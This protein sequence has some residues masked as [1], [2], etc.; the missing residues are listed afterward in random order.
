MNDNG[1]LTAELI[2]TADPSDAIKG[3]ER[4]NTG[5]KELVEGVDALARAQKSANE[6]LSQYG[7]QLSVIPFD[8]IDDANKALERQGDLLRANANIDTLP[9][10]EVTPRRQRSAAGG[11]GDGKGSDRDLLRDEFGDASS[12]LSALSGALSAVGAESAA[13]ATQFASDLT[14]GLEYIKVLGSSVAAIAL[15]AAPFLVVGG[16]VAL[17]L[18]EI[19]R[20]EQARADAI[21]TSAAAITNA[22]TQQVQVSQLIAAGET[23]AVQARLKAAKDEMDL[24][25]EVIRAS[26]DKKAA[27]EAEFDALLENTRAGKISEQEYV[28]R[29]AVLQ[30]EIDA[31]AKVIEDATPLYQDATA[32]FDSLSIAVNTSGFEAAEA[33]NQIDELT[34]KQRSY[35]DSVDAAL[36]S[37]E[38]YTAQIDELNNS[39]ATSNT[40][41]AV[42]NILQSVFD[43]TEASITAAEKAE[44]ALTAQGE[45][46]DAYYKRINE[47][48]QQ[49]NQKAVDTATAITE[50]QD[51]ARDDEVKAV[52]TFNK[53]IA[54]IEADARRKRAEAEQGMSDARLNFDV[55]AFKKASEAFDK[56]DI[57]EDKGKRRAQREFDD[58]KTERDKALAERIAALNTELEVFQA[59][60][61]TRLDTEQA[62]FEESE[63]KLIEREEQLEQ[64]A[65]DRAERRDAF[66]E[67]LGNLRQQWAA[68]DHDKRIDQL[69]V[70]RTAAE[71]NYQAELKN[72]D[73]V[74]G[75]IHK[76]KEATDEMVTSVGDFLNIVGT[77][78]DTLKDP[79][80]PLP[81][82]VGTAPAPI[83]RDSGGTGIAGQPYLIGKGAQ[84]ELFIPQTNG[85]FYPNAGGRGGS[86]SVTV[87]VTGN[88][89]GGAVSQSELE[90][91]G[92]GVYKYVDLSQIETIDVVGMA[93][94]NKSRVT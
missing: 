87:I 38:Q 36:Q 10:D 77:T 75:A 35:R 34:E 79:F 46:E 25:G 80:K 60:T 42:T 61:K 66:E 69:K 51:Q 40:R 2:L 8:V 21:K 43:A 48:Q 19:T 56:A 82:E 41:T 93:I 32:K 44:D 4:V 62:A 53:R 94:N 90:A 18:S 22:V 47:I 3:I 28:S 81:S 78:L 55:L 59:N 26:A 64:R 71:G 13:T 92:L 6:V 30:R 89:V 11:A 23:D 7:K 63:R 15:Q 54:Q 45:R 24:Q 14:G 70:Q 37:V 58:E 86:P 50:L 91:F 88:N 39:F 74:T 85:A 72:L 31:N 27:L 65:E 67:Q 68:D 12:G 83:S 49:S 73:Q 5:Q 33:A 20:Q 17:L 57:K 29:G 84:P 16:G 76:Q 52:D 1:D 9:F